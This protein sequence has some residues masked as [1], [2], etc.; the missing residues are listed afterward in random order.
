MPAPRDSN[1]SAKL[2][3][4][5]RAA[6]SR[7][8]YE[9]GTD[10][11]RH[12]LVLGNN[13][14]DR[15]EL[16]YDLVTS[17]PDYHHHTVEHVN[18]DTRLDDAQRKE[19]AAR[20]AE[21]NL[22]ETKGACIITI[23]VMRH[24]EIIAF[25]GANHA[26]NRKCYVA[27]Q[28]REGIKEDPVGEQDPGKTAESRAW[29]RAAKKAYPLWRFKRDIPKDEGLNVAELARENV[30][31]MIAHESAEAKRLAST[32]ALLDGKRELIDV[33]GANMKMVSTEGDR[34]HALKDPYGH[35]LPE[36]GTIK[37]VGETGT[38]DPYHA[39][40]DVTL[41]CEHCGNWDTVPHDQSTTPICSGGCGQKMRPATDLELNERAEEQQIRQEDLSL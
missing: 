5:A 23:Y 31:E 38:P 41:L 6:L 12:W 14:Y 35:R 19:R 25:P 29:R 27:V 8:A 30:S 18:D 37:G 36:V 39:D 26:G 24:G 2:A 3:P 32:S 33:P 21:W 11:V 40:A 1:G 4:L 7:F 22:P 28:K 10:P 13:V 16:W 15:A 20:R 17:E 9:M 34:I